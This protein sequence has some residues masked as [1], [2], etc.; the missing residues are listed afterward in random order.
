[1]TGPILLAAFSAGD[2]D[3]VAKK[4][5]DTHVAAAIGALPDPTWANLQGKPTVFPPA[6]HSAATIKSGTVG[7]AR[8]PTGV[9]ATKGAVKLS[10]STGS[11]S[12][13]ASGVAATPKAVKA[14]F[15]KGVAA[16]SA[17]GHSHVVYA[18]TSHTHSTYLKL[19]G[20]V[21]SGNLTVAGT[22]YINKAE[23]SGSMKR[24][25]TAEWAPYGFKNIQIQDSESAP[26]GGTWG[27]VLLNYGNVVAL[28]GVWV[29]T[30]HKGWKHIAKM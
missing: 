14:A 1:M 10:D 21:V 13:A 5:V 3:A 23:V 6:D 30:Q 19:T 11:S 26:T 20:G 27:D 16:L 28:N 18:A 24:F 9:A 12:S 7:S 15:D 4:Y 22:T 17:A 2:G 25:G 29:N 8:L